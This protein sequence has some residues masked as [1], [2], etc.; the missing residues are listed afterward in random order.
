MIFFQIFLAFP[1][2]VSLKRSVNRLYLSDL[3]KRRFSF[4]YSSL[5]DFSSSSPSASP[6]YCLKLICR[7]PLSAFAAASLCCSYLAFSSYIFYCLDSP[8]SSASGCLSSL[9]L[10]LLC[11]FSLLLLLFLFRLRWFGFLPFLPRGC[12]VGAV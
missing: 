7:A 6:C 5:L 1:S 4:A 11:F 8:S 2:P 12:F 3:T 9:R 10:L